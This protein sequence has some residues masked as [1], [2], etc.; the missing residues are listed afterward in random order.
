MVGKLELYPGEML[1]ALRRQASR[2][3]REPRTAGGL[4]TSALW[5]EPT[6]LRLRATR[7]AYPS[8]NSGNALT[9]ALTVDHHHARVMGRRL[10]ATSVVAVLPR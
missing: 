6:A 9:A 10:A 8:L 3:R 2:C 7:L 4:S 5:Q 1:D